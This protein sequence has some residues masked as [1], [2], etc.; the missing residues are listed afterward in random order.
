MRVGV[1]SDSHGYTGRLSTLLM[2]MEAEGPLDA[3]IHLGDG[4]HDLSD[5]GVPLP[6]LYQV[7]G[8]CDFFRSD[9]RM[10][11]E[12]SGARLL[13][14]HGHYQNVK[15]NR[16]QLFAAALDE[17]VHAALYGHTHIQKMEWRNGLLLLNPGSVMNGCY[18]ILHINRLG[19][20]DAR[21]YGQE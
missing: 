18:A 9:T 8:N 14:T 1:I 21:L 19:A 2:M 6:P 12:L 4:Y 17:K 11:V 3:I 13:L 20:I 5:L 10:T 15:Q 16:D 7:A